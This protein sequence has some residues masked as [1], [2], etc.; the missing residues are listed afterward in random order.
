MQ[1]SIWT[2]FI[3][4][5][6]GMLLVA[7]CTSPVSTNTTPAATPTPQIIYV[8][9]LVTPTPTVANQSST[10]TSVMT[11]STISQ[12]VKMDEAFIDYIDGNQIYEAMTALQSASPGSY[13]ISTGYNAKPKE[14][15]DRLTALI[16]KA[17]KPASE[18][19][20]A[21]RTA[22]MDALAEMDGNTAGFSRYR[23]AMQT[24]ILAKNAAESEMHSV[25]SFLVDAIH[26]N[27]LGDDVKSFNV[28][29]TGLH[30]FTLHHTGDRNFAITLKDD[31]GKYIALLVNEIGDY[32]GKDSERLTVG[33]YW[34]NIKAD[35][36]WTIAITQ[37]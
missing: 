6:M 19:M 18:K 31:D 5:S 10:V 17:P 34:L 29:E 20:K 15:A 12:D 36:A 37:G 21:Y 2:V 9:V 25:G 35:G 16:Y 27:G 33:R 24:V 3:F 22:M 13:S 30:I 4:L 11:E 26:L 23:D 7:G 8:T 1:K 14:E 28:T 32:S